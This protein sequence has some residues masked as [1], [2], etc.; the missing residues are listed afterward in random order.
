MSRPRL[1]LLRLAATAALLL[2]AFSVV[3]WLWYP[4]AYFGISGVGR[5]LLV[6][7][8]VG[9]VI[10][11]ALSAFV[12]KPGKKHLALDLGVLAAVEVAAVLAA[13]TVLYVR[14]PHFSVFAV[15]RFEAVALREVDRTAFADT[16]L[17]SR[18]GH[19][20]R[21]VYAE[22]PTDP[23][24][25][26]RLID[27]TLMQGEPDIDR[28]PEYW[29]PYAQGVA[30]VRDAALPFAVLLAGDERSARKAARWLQGSG[31]EARELIYLPLRGRLRDAATI[32]HADTGFPVATL[33]IDPWRS[34][35]QDNEPAGDVE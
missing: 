10:G 19:E 5:H 23:D 33:D 1:F 15:D 27:E 4:G 28:R 18:P 22:M 21:L 20:P 13:M 17:R 2:L 3:R 14:Q 24:A 34:A 16:S 6:L 8:A 29:R 26:S 30:H 31:F 9:V 12:Y 35:P 32:L 11:P 25:L 7:A